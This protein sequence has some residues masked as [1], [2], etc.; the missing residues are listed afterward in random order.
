ML[1]THQTVSNHLDSIMCTRTSVSCPPRHEGFGMVSI[2]RV[3][4]PDVLFEANY[5]VRGY[6][7]RKGR[8]RGEGQDPMRWDGLCGWRGEGRGV[9]PSRMSHRGSDAR[10]RGN[11]GPSRWWDAAITGEGC[12]GVRVCGRGPRGALRGERLVLALWQVP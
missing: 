4:Q 12:E 7:G 8:T 5:G 9:S 2:L 11:R 6:E 1:D 3:A 10:Y